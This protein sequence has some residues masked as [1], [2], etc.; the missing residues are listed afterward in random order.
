[1]NTRLP[2]VLL[3]ALTGLSQ[4][5]ACSCLLCRQASPEAVCAACLQSS[6][7]R[8]GKA[9]LQCGIALNTAGQ[10][11][12]ACLQ[13]PPAFDI[14][15]CAT[16]YQPPQDQLVLALKFAHQ[17]PL[18]VLLARAIRD[19]ILRQPG[20]VLPDLICPVP[21]SPQRLQER[22]FNQALEIARPLA[23]MLGVACLPYA[24]HRVRHTQ[25]QAMLAPADRRR[26][27]A[28]AFSP[29]ADYLPQLQ[30]RH[31]AIVDDVI[32][33]GM[34]LHEIATMLKRYGAKQVSNYVFART[35]P[36]FE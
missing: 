2:P 31:I 28:K 19:A 35:P 20:L 10:R 27:I 1:M 25:Q 5:A 22:G 18:A 14:T 13:H 34:T 6:L 29:A 9:C 16:D 3:H 23:A 21:L 26:N 30:V 11:C 15:I 32:T 8:S 24:I 36:H 17:L 12:G 33:T 7:A 4:I